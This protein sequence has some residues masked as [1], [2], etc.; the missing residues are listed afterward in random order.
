MLLAV[1]GIQVN[2]ADDNG[3]TPLSIACHGGHLKVVELVLAMDGVQVNQADGKGVTPLSIACHKGQ[4]KVV[5]LLLAVVGIQ[6]NQADINGLT[7]LM[8]ATF[9]S[10]TDIVIRFLQH[11]IGHN[12][13]NEWFCIN[14][15]KPSGRIALY[16][17]ALLL[18]QQH[19]PLLDF[20][21]CVLSAKNALVPT[22]ALKVFKTIWPPLI[23]FTIES[24]LLPTKQTRRTMQQVISLFNETLND[25]SINEETQ[26][27][28]V[29]R[30]A[31]VDSVR[32]LLQQEGILL[33][34]L[35]S[36][37]SEEED[38]D[39]QLYETA[40]NCAV[41]FVEDNDDD[42]VMAKGIQ[43][44]ELLREAGG[45]AREIPREEWLA[46]QNELMELTTPGE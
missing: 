21:S 15:I 17:Y 9:Q 26:L 22:S 28:E 46:E 33:D 31:D 19:Q 32:F 23:G 10:H 7:P 5:E 30:E 13:T 37:S 16:K 12:N 18:P 41:R 45:N 27:Y 36:R 24:F 4:L 6:V 8:V 42:A 34:T 25:I 1:V 14:K 11:G 44:V 40:L 39:D 35:S 20:H 43:I 38:E 29:T 3:V 2:Q